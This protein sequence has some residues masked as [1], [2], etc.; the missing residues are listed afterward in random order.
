MYMHVFFLCLGKAFSKAEKR[1]QNKGMLWKQR[2]DQ[3][4][5]VVNT[6]TTFARVGSKV[7][8]PPPPAILDTHACVHLCCVCVCVCV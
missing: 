6:K 7:Y 3:K 8:V 5:G 1:E 2:L 4:T